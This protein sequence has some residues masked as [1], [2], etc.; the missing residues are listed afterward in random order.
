M[1]KDESRPAE[2]K[3]VFLD[4]DECSRFRVAGNGND[5][6]I[7]ICAAYCVENHVF[8]PVP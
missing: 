8:I 5:D 6:N 1:A 3:D 4:A 7:V 2:K